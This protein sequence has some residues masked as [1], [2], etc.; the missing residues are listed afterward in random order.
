MRLLRENDRGDW[1]EL[2][3]DAVVQ[4][5]TGGVI[6]RESISNSLLGDFPNETIENIEKLSDLLITLESEGRKIGLLFLEA[7]EV[8]CFFIQAKNCNFQCHEKEIIS[9]QFQFQ[10]RG[11]QI[12][13]LENPQVQ[14]YVL[15]LLFSD[16][17]KD[18]VGDLKDLLN[19]MKRSVSQ[20]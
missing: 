20:L 15:K 14:E 5:S 10:Q 12:P 17:F 2:Q 6:I 8:D 19:S 11:L 16:E 13:Q 18:F 1:V 7:K 3:K 4:V 9:K